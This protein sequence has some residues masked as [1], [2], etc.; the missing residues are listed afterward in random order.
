MKEMNRVLEDNEISI[1]IKSWGRRKKKKI[2]IPS[3]VIYDMIDSN[4][5]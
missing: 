2:Q 3:S 5:I 4:R 1:N